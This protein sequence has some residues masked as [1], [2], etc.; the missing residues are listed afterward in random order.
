MI[1]IISLFDSHGKFNRSIR[2]ERA[3][4]RFRD[5]VAYVR[6]VRGND[7]MDSGGNEGWEQWNGPVLITVKGHDGGQAILMPDEMGVN[8]AQELLKAAAKWKVKEIKGKVEKRQFEEAERVIEKDFGLRKY[9]HTDAETL[10]ESLER[11]GM[12]ID[13]LVEAT[14]IPR[15]VFWGVLEHR[16]VFNRRQISLISRALK[17][18]VAEWE[19]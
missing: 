9:G 1:G 4:V 7:W 12:T 17:I 3:V 11:V 13:M 2:V 8:A 10:N 16:R 14:K 18:G 19:K 6:G 5:F 15:Y